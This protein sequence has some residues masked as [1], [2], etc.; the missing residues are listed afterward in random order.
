V[1]DSVSIDPVRTDYNDTLAYFLDEGWRGT[2]ESV[3]TITKVRSVTA[4]SDPEA[5]VYPKVMF[6][7]CLDS[8][9]TDLV[10]KSGKS[11]KGEG[12]DFDAGV[13]GAYEEPGQ[14]WF[15]EYWDFEEGGKECAP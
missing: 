5:F 1:F 15:V 13:V 8:S 12:S 9:A 3:I 10:D 6:D 2:G 4:E 7:V 14:G 11:V